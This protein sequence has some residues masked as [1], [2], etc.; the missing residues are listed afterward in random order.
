MESRL[1]FLPGN[2]SAA[3]I[4]TKRPWPSLCPKQTCSDFC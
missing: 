3:R 1:S 2:R 4:R